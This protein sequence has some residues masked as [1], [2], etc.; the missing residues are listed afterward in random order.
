MARL[1]GSLRPSPQTNDVPLCICKALAPNRMEMVVRLQVLLGVATVR[2]PQP[3]EKG[4][5]EGEQEIV[6]GS[7]GGGRVE[8]GIVFSCEEY[9]LD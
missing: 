9:I 5:M 3:W 1:G 8:T 2:P 6:G 4:G 7:R